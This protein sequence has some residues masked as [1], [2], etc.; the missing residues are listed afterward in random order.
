MDSLTARMQLH[1]LRRKHADYG[2]QDTEGR[3]AV[4][5]VEE[6]VEQGK[7]FPF[8]QRSASSYYPFNPFQLYSSI[9]G[10][11]TASHELIEAAREYWT[12]L[13]EEKLGVT[14]AR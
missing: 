2:A 14:I 3:E 6:A 13:T 8:V 7:S 4:A 10:W 11:E 9:D 12:A 5:I 1:A